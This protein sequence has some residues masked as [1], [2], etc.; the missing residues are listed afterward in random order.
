MAKGFEPVDTYIVRS[1]GPPKAQSFTFSVGISIFLS[2]VEVLA[3]RENFG[4]STLYFRFSFFLILYHGSITQMADPSNIAAYKIP[5]RSI[6]NP[7]TEKLSGSPSEYFRKSK[8]TRS[9]SEKC[10][11][12]QTRYLKQH[13]SNTHKQLRSWSTNRNF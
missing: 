7:I 4:I 8:T 1:F 2:K 10:Q 6:V 13:I 11:V 5:A 12:N 9:L 3:V